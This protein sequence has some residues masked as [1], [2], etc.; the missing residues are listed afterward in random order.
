MKRTL[1]IGL[2]LTMVASLAFAQAGSIR[3]ASEVSGV[4]CNFADAGGLVQVYILHVDAPGATAS[5][6]RLDISAV[7]WMHLGDTWNFP[8]IIGTS[9]VGVSVAYGGCYT[10]PIALGTINFFGT[11]APACSM[12]SIVADPGALSGAIE[13]VDCDE[14][15]V[16]PTGGAGIVNPDGSQDCDCSTPV[17]ET[18]WGGVKALYN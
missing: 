11:S 16:F 1:L 9:I 6:F 15:K 12:I 17:Q 3:I 14:F 10:A 2:C 7:G 4:D 18:T 5:Q 13:A 8:T